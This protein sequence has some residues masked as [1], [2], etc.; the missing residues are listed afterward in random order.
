MVNKVSDKIKAD[1]KPN[2]KGRKKIKKS[3]LPLEGNSFEFLCLSLKLIYGV[4]LFQ[5]FTFAFVVLAMFNS[6]KKKGPK[7]HKTLQKHK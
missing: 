4:I 7:R 3:D 5:I 6:C 1:P 2:K